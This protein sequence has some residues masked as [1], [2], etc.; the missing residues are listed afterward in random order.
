MFIGFDDEDDDA[1]NV[2]VKCLP[3]IDLKRIF[4]IVTLFFCLCIGV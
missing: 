3:E 2:F 4:A 1:F